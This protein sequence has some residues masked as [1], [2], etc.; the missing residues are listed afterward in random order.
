MTTTAQQ[1]PEVVANVD[2]AAPVAT[3]LAGAANTAG[4]DGPV[5]AADDPGAVSTVAKPHLVE[6]QPAAPT[7]P[8]MP[9]AY[10]NTVREFLTGKQ[11]PVSAPGKRIIEK[12]K[13]KVAELQMLQKGLNEAG[14]KIRQVQ[15]QESA[16]AGEINGMVAMVWEFE[17]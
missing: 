5:T 14:E 8:Q 11:V 7:N 4:A 6:S 12:L 2:R 15:I 13:T 9:D 16:L 10:N 1:T 3:G 17:Q